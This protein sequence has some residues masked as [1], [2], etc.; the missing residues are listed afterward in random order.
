MTAQ[1]VIDLATN[2]ELRTLS[3]KTDISAVMGFI[4]L[5]LIELYKRFPIVTKEHLI[6][7]LEGVEIYTLPSDFMWLV[8]AYGEIP[9][10]DSRKN[11]LNLPINDEENPLS[12]NT[13]SWNTV[14]IP[15][16]VTGEFVSLIYVGSPVLVTADTLGS[17]LPIPDQM[18]EALL[19]YMGYRGHGSLDG[20]V[21]SESN[22]HYQRFELS[23]KRLK[24]EGM[25]TSEGVGMDQRIFN[26]GFL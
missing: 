15:A 5:G 8:G 25:I 20:K 9:Y 26:R 3:I 14:Q 6:T 17:A 21:D 19:N 10:S 22:T 4:N 24:N 16:T 18:V 11:L 23:V 7:I 1:E 12:V 2:G 13:V